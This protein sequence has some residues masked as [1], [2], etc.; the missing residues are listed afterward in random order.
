M[1]L[2]EDH[3]VVPQVDGETSAVRDASVGTKLVPYNV[4]GAEPLTGEF[5]LPEEVTTGAS[6]VNCVVT[7]P[8]CMPIVSATELRGPPPLSSL[9]RSCVSEFH[10]AVAQRVTPIRGSGVVSSKPKLVPSTVRTDPDVPGA[11][12]TASKLTTGAS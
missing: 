2:A 5:G 8:T 10:D 1:E 6:Y 12:T 9:H 4:N 3:E 11:F 7:V